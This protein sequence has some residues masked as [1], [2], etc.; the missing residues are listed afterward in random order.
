MLSPEKTK[1]THIR[2]G[3]NFLGWNIRKYG[4]QGKY[5][6]KPA[7]NNTSA[8]LRKVVGI[9]KGNKTIKQEQLIALLNPIIRGWGN[10]HQGSSKN[11]P[12]AVKCGE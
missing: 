6:Q 7:D 12:Y 2:D 3:F 5:L 10:Y 1:I 9:I 8:F 4:K 11:S